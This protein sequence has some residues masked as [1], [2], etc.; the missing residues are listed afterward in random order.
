MIIPE[1]VLNIISK[2][3]E[4][5]FEAFCVGGCVRDSLLGK[6][7]SDWDITTSALPEDMLEI[8]KDYAVIPTGIKH[9]TV[10][11]ISEG[12]PIEVTTYR[13]DGDYLDGR[14]PESVRFSRNIRDDLSRRDFT[15]NAIAYSAS[16][17]MVDLF[18][19]QSDL[20]SKIIR[21]VGDP[22]K[23]FT[24]DALRIMRAFRFAAVLGFEIEEETALAILRCFPLL[25]NIAA[26]RIMAE[27][28]KLLTA[29]MPCGILLRF[30]DV[31]SFILGQKN[32]GIKKIWEENIK[33]LSKTPCVLPL[34]LAV[35]IRGL[36]DENTIL[37][38]LRYD[39]KTQNKVKILLEMRKIKI[40]D[41]KLAV[42]KLLSEFGEE[43]VSLY[44][45]MKKAEGEA[46]CIIYNTEKFLAEI[47]SG[48]ECYTLKDLMVTGRDLKEQLALE[49][50]ALGA[51]LDMLLDAVI[52]EKCENEKTALLEFARLHI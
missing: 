12:N 23:R 41:T 21:C 31:F 20:K 37:Q 33:V 44:I 32:S 2:I 16:C 8:F 28:S 24:E 29:D 45:E 4:N 18:C 19:G 5:G 42:K 25:E 35:L 34:R 9:G 52:C 50:K 13:I 36:D 30:F 14:H 43:M 11:V 47:L 17:G 49:G 48:D 3:E 40:P 1:F 27:L 22:E 51:M 15:V 7:P 39:K 10:T 38:R 46:F 6:T 26:E